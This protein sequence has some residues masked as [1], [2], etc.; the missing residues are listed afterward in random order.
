MRDNESNNYEEGEVQIT[1]KNEENKNNA[2]IKNDKSNNII[3]KNQ[4]VQVK[5]EQKTT[6][7]AETKNV[8]KNNTKTKEKVSSQEPQKRE[9]AVI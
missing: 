6:S 7:N 3:V 1:N 8:E 5:K 2:V 4:T 9:I